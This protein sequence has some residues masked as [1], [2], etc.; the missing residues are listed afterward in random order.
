MINKRKIK[1]FFHS[2]NIF[3]ILIGLGLPWVVVL[4]A[5]RDAIVV[6]TDNLLAS[7]FLLFAT[8]VA[9]FTLLVLRRWVLGRKAGWLLIGVY[10]LYLVY[11]VVQLI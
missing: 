9:V 3:D 8:V 5:G 4:A 6:S 11:T 1:R 10:V 7:I 2:I